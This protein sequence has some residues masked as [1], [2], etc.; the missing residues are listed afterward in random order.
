M[1]PIPECVKDLIDIKQLIRPGLAATY[2]SD[3]SRGKAR[4]I[5]FGFQRRISVANLF[6]TI[7]PD[8]ASTFTILIN[9]GN[10]TV[11]YLV[12]GELKFMFV[13]ASES[14]NARHVPTASL[15][16]RDQRKMMIGDNP[17]L[18]AQYALRVF[19]AYI[20]H[21]LGWD[22]IRKRSKIGGGG[23]GMLRW[24]TAADEA[25]KG[26]DN[27]LHIV[28]GVVGFPK[29]T[30]AFYIAMEEL[31]TADGGQVMNTEDN[32]A[33]DKN[34][35]VSPITASTFETR[36]VG[37]IYIYIYFYLFVSVNIFYFFMF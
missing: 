14:T 21:F 12:N 13:K 19:K 24:F 4:Q 10:L 11:E 3:E 5:G 35:K 25:Q 18:S 23:Y 27:H 6:V 20:E 7:S 29:T 30:E 34:G 31:V 1:G 33:V 22:P 32:E 26:A 9:N 8:T 17:Y 37:N 16:N 36:F 2:G 15:P 28:G